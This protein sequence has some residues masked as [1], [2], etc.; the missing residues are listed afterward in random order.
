MA[1]RRAI[2]NA[3]SLALAAASAVLL[4]AP[5]AWACGGLF[6]N[7]T[8]PV[9]Q[10]AE[11][12]LFAV[13]EAAGE[14]H[15]HVRITYQ[16]P[17]TEFGWLLP[18]PPGV[19]TALSS[20]ALFQALDAQHAPRF[21]LRTEFE[22]AQ[23]IAADAGAGFEEDPAGG[24]V[25]VLSREPIGPYDRAILEVDDVASLRAWLDE[26]A[27]QI[28]EGT[29][30]K[31][32]PYVAAGAVFVAL[33]LLPD[34]DAGDIV[35]LR[36][37]FPGNRAAIPIV[38]TSVAAD[39]DMGI[40]V[41]VLG[42][43][44]AVPV[45]YRH[46][47][48]NEAA[49]DW[50][51]GGDNYADVVSQAVD[52]AGGRAFVT[53]FAGPIDSLIVQTLRPLT[54]AQAQAFEDLGQLGDLEAIDF[55]LLRDPDVQRILIS[56]IE[57]APG[58]TVE[59]YLQCPSCNEQF[60]EHPIDGAAIAARIDE[61]VA[62]PRVHLA[63]L[64]AAHPYL[65]RLYTTLSPDEMTRDPVFSFNQNLDD[66]AA[67]RTAT[68]HIPCDGDNPQF[69]DAVIALEDGRE[70]TPESF[71]ANAV[72]RRDGMTFRGGAVPAARLVEQLAA[73]GPPELIEEN[74]VVDRSDGSGCDCDIAGSDDPGR[75]G[76]LPVFALLLTA[77]L[78]RCRRR[79]RNGREH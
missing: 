39:P 64:F 44:R 10:A 23:A 75:R 61:E 62:A 21:N 4:S 37:S 58:L 5:A 41:H 36:L 27:F 43:A 12:I 14:I 29:D 49:I 15:M 38:P 22:C 47:H 6:C 68:R 78:I 79:A 56:S 73:D 24:G 72:R 54:D 57:P 59:A 8:Q 50:P 30:S 48:I 26:N 32:E 18:M 11:R 33:K 45:N 17:P 42:D 20:E 76:A 55:G 16:G 25:A 51:N 28:P 19:D 7:A 77:A 71:E 31:L 67:V 34:S 35:P 1:K 40:I 63:E 74:V 65:T 2:R 9:N 46:V 69:A 53:D 3:Q 70:L 66:V 52:E 13:D 60:A